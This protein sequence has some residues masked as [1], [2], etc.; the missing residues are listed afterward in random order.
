MS[1]INPAPGTTGQVTLV[2]TDAAGTLSGN[3]AVPALQNMTVNNSNDTY[4]WSQ[5]DAGSKYQIATTSTNS[6]ACNIVVDEAT[7]F[8]SGANTTVAGTGILGLSQKK[9]KVGFTINIGEG[10]TVSGSGYIT[11][12]APTVSADQPVWVSPLTIAVV[13]DYTFGGA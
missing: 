11:G 9:T 12:L 13:G 6:V 2:L 7:F 3:L 5:L 4:T 1:Y 8:G 10:R